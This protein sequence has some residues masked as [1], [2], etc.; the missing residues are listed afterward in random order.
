M[1]CKEHLLHFFLQGKIS[2]SQ[3][4]YKFM[5]NLQTMIQNNMRVTSNQAN[6]FDKLVSKYA[7]Q[8]TKVAL[9]HAEL[10]AL[11]WKTMVVESTPEYTSA[12]ASLFEDVITLRVPFNKAFISYFRTIGGNPFEWF[13]E[14]KLYRAPFSTVALKT[15]YHTLPKH[16]AVVNYCEVLNNILEDLKHYEGLIW[17]PTLMNIND[18]IVMGA[19]NPA[20]IDLISD[21]DLNITTDTLYK[22]SRYQFPVHPNFYRDDAR[23]RFAYEYVTEIDIDN[24]VQVASW[25]RHLKVQRVLLDRILTTN[26]SL[27]SE[28]EAVLTGISV[29]PTTP[30]HEFKRDSSMPP[31]SF[32][33]QAHSHFNNRLNTYAS[34][35]IDKI[36]VLKN[37]RPVEVK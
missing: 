24:L 4:D 37:A 22:L 10:K 33:L 30:G 3:Y 25:M 21:V 29:V 18:R 8:L 12:K 1:D 32:L 7:K 13:K 19:A 23:L 2:L 36:V 15:L 16:F 9:V 27:R 11:P 35:N 17:E 34:Y 26:R 31:R 5:A 28:I 14:E 20:V 6:L